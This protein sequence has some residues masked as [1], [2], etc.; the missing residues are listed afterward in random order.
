MRAFPD[1]TRGGGDSPEYACRLPRLDR[2]NGLRSFQY[3]DNRSCTFVVPS[4]TRVR[5]FL[6]GIIIIAH[7]CTRTPRPARRN[8][9]GRGFMQKTWQSRLPRRRPKPPML[10]V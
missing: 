5:D 1:G 6:D 10:L 8:D 7:A 9:P 2:R 3:C 4:R